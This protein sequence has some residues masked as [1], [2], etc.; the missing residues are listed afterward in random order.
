[1]GLILWS[2]IRLEWQAVTRLKQALERIHSGHG[3]QVDTESCG[4]ARLECP[5]R[6]FRIPVPLSRVEDALRSAFSS[7]S[8]GCLIRLPIADCH[9][10]FR[11]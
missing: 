11:F 5:A 6:A 10:K 8:T 7:Q 2:A 1:M 9:Q 3:I 4:S